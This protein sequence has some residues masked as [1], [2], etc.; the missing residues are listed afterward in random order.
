MQLKALVRRIGDQMLEAHRGA[1]VWRGRVVIF[2][3]DG[4]GQDE[5][6]RDYVA[7]LQSRLH[8]TG[9]EAGELAVDDEDSYTWLIP[10][11]V[12]NGM[13]ADEVRD[14]AEALVWECWSVG[15]GGAELA[16]FASLQRNIASGVIAKSRLS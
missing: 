11:T 8:A 9:L 5:R 14:R 12:P 13:T 16:S 2:G 15:R 4:Y 7:R 6:V 1:I 3:N 10:V